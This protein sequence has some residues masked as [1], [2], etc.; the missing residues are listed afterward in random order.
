[1]GLEIPSQVFIHFLKTRR[2]R[3]EKDAGTLRPVVQINGTG[4][5][6]ASAKITRDQIGRAR[7][8]E[9]YK[10]ARFTHSVRAIP[11]Q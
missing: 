9:P 11:A 3:H 10:T 7:P 2:Y 8:A 4:I 5:G 6:R 1:M